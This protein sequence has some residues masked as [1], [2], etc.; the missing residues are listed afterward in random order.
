MFVSPPLEEDVR[1]SG[2]PTA[3]L[4]AQPSGDAHVS[5]ILMDYSEEGQGGANQIVS[6]G[7]QDAKSVH[8]R[9]EEKP[10]RSDRNYVIEFDQMPQDYVFE[11]G[12][13]IGVVVT[14]TDNR[15]FPPDGAPPADFELDLRRSRTELPI[16]AGRDALG[17]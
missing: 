1:L 14:G 9:W 4:H 6:R 2:T 5:A 17:F 3:R 10:I 12:R 11:A 13:R 15:I 16:V 7:W 8:S